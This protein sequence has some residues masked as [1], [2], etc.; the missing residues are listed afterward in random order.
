VLG[1]RRNAARS[2]AANRLANGLAHDPGSRANARDEIAA[3][4]TLGT[5]AT[6]ARLVVIPSER[7]PRAAISASARTDPA[8]TCSGAERV[9]PTHGT[10]RIRPPS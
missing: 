3:S 5:S 4:R 1:G 9:G 8:A 6:G 7:N 2:P 10:R